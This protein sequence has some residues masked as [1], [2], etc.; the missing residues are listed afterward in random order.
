[1]KRFVGS[2][3][4]LSMVPRYA[5]AGSNDVIPGAGS[6]MCKQEVLV[7]TSYWCKQEVTVMT[8]Y[9][10]KQEVTVMTSYWCKQEVR[11][12]RGSEVLRWEKVWK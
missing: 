3:P 8:S 11:R 6:K 7:M 5:Q 12:M 1:M 4:N 2:K 9:W 10:C